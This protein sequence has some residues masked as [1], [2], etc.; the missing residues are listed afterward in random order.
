MILRK[1]FSQLIAFCLAA[2]ASMPSGTGVTGFSN[3]ISDDLAQ[4]LGKSP[5]SARIW[6]SSSDLPLAGRVGIQ[7]DSAEGIVYFGQPTTGYTRT[8]PNSLSVGVPFLDL[9]AGLLVPDNKS[10][11]QFRKYNDSLMVSFIDYKISGY[12][13]A[14][15][16][17]SAQVL[18]EDSKTSKDHPSL[19]PFRVNWRLTKDVVQPAFSTQANIKFF[20][21][22][23]EMPGVPYEWL[24]GA[25]LQGQD[26]YF[27][28]D[29]R[30]PSDS[31]SEFSSF[32]RPLTVTNTEGTPSYWRFDLGDGVGGCDATSPTRGCG[33]G[34]QASWI[35]DLEM[36]PLWGEFSS[37]ELT[38]RAVGNSI[39]KW[40]VWF[41]EEG[42]AHSD[43]FLTTE[44]SPTN[45]VGFKTDRILA[46]QF[47]SNAKSVFR[48]DSMANVSVDRFKVMAGYVLTGGH[49][50][51]SQVILRRDQPP[52]LRF[53]GIA[54][55]TV[56]PGQGALTVR[57]L[58][59]TQANPTV[60]LLK[61]ANV[62]RSGTADAAGVISW[63]DIPSGDYTV[64]VAKERFSYQPDVIAWNATS[65]VSQILVQQYEN[66]PAF[67]PNPPTP[68]S[69]DEGQEVVIQLKNLASDPRGA[70]YSLSWSVVSVSGDPIP[71]KLD[72]VLKTLRLGLVNGDV[73]GSMTLQL[74]ATSSGGATTTAPL[75]V[76][77]RPVN[78]APRILATDWSVAAGA[79]LTV[80]L[81][82]T[83]LGKP[84]WVED[85]DDGFLNLIWSAKLASGA[86]EGAV[87]TVVDRKLNFQA[88]AGFSGVVVI[89]LGVKD[90]IGA[91]TVKQIPIKVV[92]P[93]VEIYGLKTEQTSTGDLKASFF[94]RYSLEPV[95]L[96]NSTVKLLNPSSGTWGAAPARLVVL[97][98]PGFRD[99]RWMDGQ[100]EVLIDRSAQWTAD[101]V[102]LPLSQVLQNG[103]SLSGKLPLS[104]DGKTLEKDLSYLGLDLSGPV[105]L[106]SASSSGN[107]PLIHAEWKWLEPGTPKFLRLSLVKGTDR[108]ER[109]VSIPS[110]A[111]SVDVPWVDPSWTYDGAIPSTLPYLRDGQDYLVELIGED[112]LGNQG[113]GSTIVGVPSSKY[114]LRITTL[115]LEEVPP[116]T[117][118][119]CIEGKS[120]WKGCTYYNSYGGDQFTTGRILEVPRD[121][122]SI[123]LEDSRYQ[124]EIVD[125]MPGSKKLG[126]VIFEHSPNYP[127][128][129][130]DRDTAPDMKIYLHRRNFLS[131][132][133]V[134]VEQEIGTGDFVFKFE[135]NRF[136]GGIIDTVLLGLTEIV[137]GVKRDVEIHLPVTEYN[138]STPLEADSWTVRRTLEQIRAQGGVGLFSG[139]KNRAVRYIGAAARFRSFGNQQRTIPVRDSVVFQA[140][141]LAR[142]WNVLDPDGPASTDDSR[143]VITSGGAAE[144][145]IDLPATHGS[146]GTLKLCLQNDNGTE[147]CNDSLVVPKAERLGFRPTVAGAFPVTGYRNFLEASDQSGIHV[148]AGQAAAASQWNVFAKASGEYEAWIH[149]STNATF[150]DFAVST[151]S[152]KTWVEN[153]LYTESWNQVG[154]I[155]L[156]QGWNSLA[157]RALQGASIQGVLLQTNDSPSPKKVKLAD[158]PFSDAA[159]PAQVTADLE[160]DQIYKSVLKVRDA[161][162][163][164][165]EKESIFPV[166]PD[167]LFGDVTLEQEQATGDLLLRAGQT[168]FIP[169]PGGF[170]VRLAPGTPAIVPDLDSAD[171]LTIRIPRSRIP[172]EF[173]GAAGLS[174]SGPLDSIRILTTKPVTYHWT[175]RS[176]WH[177]GILGSWS[178]KTNSHSETRS[179]ADSTRLSWTGFVPWK[180]A[181]D[182]RALPKPVL[183]VDYAGLDSIRLKVTG[184]DDS[185]GQSRQTMSGKLKVEWTPGSHCASSTAVEIPF[186]QIFEASATGSVLF[187]PRLSSAS[188]S[189]VGG[190]ADTAPAVP[191]LRHQWL[192]NVEGGG[193]F[194]M[195]VLPTPLA[196]EKRPWISFTIRNPSQTPSTTKLWTVPG[197]YVGDSRQNFEF[198]LVPVGTTDPSTP[199]WHQ[200]SGYS[201][202]WHRQNDELVM[203]SGDQELQIRMIDP[204]VTFQALGLRSSALTTDPTEVVSTLPF[205]GTAGMN[206]VF[207][208]APSLASGTLHGFR[209]SAVDRV[210]NVSTDSVTIST[211]AATAKLPTVGIAMSPWNGSG[212]ITGDVASATFVPDGRFVLPAD[213]QIKAWLRHRN[214]TTGALTT[215]STE[216]TVVHGTDGSWTASL[217]GLTARGQT[218]QDFE[219]GERTVLVAWVQSASGRGNRSAIDF[220]VLSETRPGIVAG[221]FLDG[222]ANTGLSFEVKEAWQ[223][224]GSSTYYADLELS[225]FKV[226]EDDTAVNHLILRGAKVAFVQEGTAKRLTNVVGGR[227][228][229]THCK[230]SGTGESLCHDVAR[231]PWTLGRWGGFLEVESVKPELQGT[232]GW[233][234]AVARAELV[235]D[236]AR[237]SR[238]SDPFQLADAGIVGSDDPAFLGKVNFSKDRFWF[239]NVVAANQAEEAFGIEACRTVIGRT[240][241]GLEI[242][243]MGCK[244]EVGPFLTFPLNIQTDGPWS[245]VG[246][247]FDSLTDPYKLTWT[248]GTG[249]GKKWIAGEPESR[250]TISVPTAA[251]TVEKSSL[252]DVRGASLWGYDIRSYKFGPTGV[253]NLVFDL[254]LPDSKLSP[255]QN[256]VAQRVKSFSGMTIVSDATIMQGAPVL[257]GT[258]TS[259]DPAVLKLGASLRLDDVVSWTYARQDGIGWVL[260]PTA[261]SGKTV[262]LSKQQDEGWKYTKIGGVDQPDDR[263]KFP[264]TTL[265]IG[266]G[267]YVS[268]SSSSQDVVISTGGATVSAKLSVDPNDDELRISVASPSVV[269]SKFFT[270]KGSMTF[271]SEVVTDPEL[272]LDPEFG[273]ADIEGTGSLGTST[274]AATKEVWIGGLPVVNAIPSG[275]YQILANRGRMFVRLFKPQMVLHDLI[276]STLSSAPSAEVQTAVFTTDRMPVAVGAELDVPSTWKEWQIPGSIGSVQLDKMYLEA[277]S[278][279]DATSKT[280]TPGLRLQ[281]PTVVKLGGLFEKMGLDGYRLPLKSV[282]MGLKAKTGGL[283]TS[284]MSLDAL[285]WDLEFETAPI[286]FALDLELTRDRLN[287]LF[288]GTYDKAKDKTPVLVKLSTQGWPIYAKYQ[289]NALEM[290]LKNWEVELTDS[291]PLSAMRNTS[292]HL[293]ELTVQTGP[294]D[295]VKTFKASGTKEFPDDLAITSDVI[296]KGFKDPVTQAVRAV[297]VKLGNDEGDAKKPYF[298]LTADSIKIGDKT[299]NL[300]CGGTSSVVKLS[301]SGDFMGEVCVEI[302][303]SL[304]I[305]PFKASKPD[306]WATGTP[307]PTPEDPKARKKI[308]LKLTVKDGEFGIT[309]QNARLR[310]IPMK[311]VFDNGVD[312]DLTATVLVKDGSLRLREA[313]AIIKLGPETE[314]GWKKA[315]G[316]FSV[317]VP[318]LRFYYNT[319]ASERTKNS[320][321]EGKIAF[322]LDPEVGMKVGKCAGGGTGLVQFDA[323]IEAMTSVSLKWDFE[324]TDFACEVAGLDL[325][326]QKLKIGT[327]ADELTVAAHVIQVSVKSDAAKYLGKGQDAK[328]ENQVA[329]VQSTN[330][331]V[332]PHSGKGFRIVNLMYDGSRQKP[333]TIDSLKPI[334]FGDLDN[335]A[336]EIPGIGVTVVSRLDVMPLFDDD[337]GVAL[338]N[339]RLALPSSMGGDTLNTNFSVLFN[340][341]SPYVHVRGKMNELPLRIKG[342][343]L[344]PDVGLDDAEMVIKFNKRLNGDEGWSFEGKAALNMQGG[345]GKLDAELA[346]ETP[347]DCKVGVCKAVVSVR[348][349]DGAR[350]PLGTTGLYIAGLK[351]AFYDG[352]YSPP[353]AQKCTGQPMD[354]GM[355]VELAVFLEAEK[356]S[357]LN[358][359]TG[360]WVQLNRINFGVYGEF[361]MMDGVADADACAAVFAGGKQFHGQVHV[362]LHALLSARGS[363]VIDIWSDNRGKSMAAEATA[364]VGLGRGAIIRSRW[365]KFPRTTTWFG[366]FVTRF[367]RFDNGSNGFTSGVRAMGKTW[368]VGFVDGGFRLG[369]V[370]QYKLAKPT[371]S[372]LFLAGSEYR[373]MPLGLV[374][375]GGEVI[376]INVG[377]AEG[378]DWRGAQIQLVEANTKAGALGGAAKIS[379][380]NVTPISGMEN[381]LVA[382]REDSANIHS[383]TWINANRTLRTLVAIPKSAGTAPTGEVREDGDANVASKV[384]DLQVLMG[385]IDPTVALTATKC[386]D[387]TS[388][389]CINGSVVD[390]RKDPA[391]V[392]R[393]Y[394]SDELALL[395][396]EETDRSEKTVLWQ[397]H[398][399]KFW[400]IPTWDTTGGVGARD[401]AIPLDIPSN[402]LTNLSSCMTPLAV[403]QRGVSL[404]D[405]RWKPGR[406]KTGRYRL[407]AGVEGV[408]LLPTL[409]A[410]GLPDSFLLDQTRRILSK[411]G[412][413]DPFA[414]AVTYPD[415]VA[416][417]TALAV[418]G[419]A[420]DSTQS[421]TSNQRRTLFARWTPQGHPDVVGHMIRWTDAKNAQHLFH[422]GADGQW[423]INVPKS[424]GYKATGNWTPEDLKGGILGDMP[425]YDWMFQVPTKLEVAPALFQRVPG[426]DSFYWAPRWDLAATWLAPTSNP[427][428]VLGNAVGGTDNLLGAPAVTSQTVHLNESKTDTLRIPVTVFNATP[429][430]NLASLYG[431]LDMELLSSTG[432]PLTPS[433]RKAA[434]AFSVDVEAW[435]LAGGTLKIPYA[436]S[437]VA[438]ARVCQPRLVS[439]EETLVL[440]TSVCKQNDTLKPATALGDYQ[441]RLRLWSE[442]RLESGKETTVMF[443]VKVV[444]PEAHIDRVGPDYLLGER[445]QKIRLEASKLWVDASGR[446]PVVAIKDGLGNWV[447]FVPNGT[448]SRGTELQLVPD[449][450]GRVD[451]NLVIQLG[452][453]YSVPN[454]N[455]FLT[456]HVFHRDAQGFTWGTDQALTYVPEPS[457]IACKASQIDDIVT[458]NQIA[459][460]FVGFYP[461]TVRLSDTVTALFSEIHNPDYVNFQVQ[462]KRGTDSVMVPVLQYDAGRVRFLLPKTLGGKDLAA[463][464]RVTLTLNI[465]DNSAGTNCQ[466]KHWTQTLTTEKPLT[467]ANIPRQLKAS[468][469]PGDILVSHP[470][471]LADERIEWVRGTPP[472]GAAWSWIQGNPTNADI[473]QTDWLNVRIRRPEAGVVWQDRWL[474]VTPPREISLGTQ[475]RT[476]RRRDTLAVGTPIGWALSPI[477]TQGHNGTSLPLMQCRWNDGTW[478]AC[479]DANLSVNLVQQGALEVR[480]GWKLFTPTGDT[481]IWEPAQSWQ[482]AARSATLDGVQRVSLRLDGVRLAHLI[483][484]QVTNAVVR[485]RRTGAEL[486]RWDATPPVVRDAEGK[487]LAQQVEV[488]DPTNKRYEAWVEVPQLIPHRSLN[489]ELWLGDKTSTKVPESLVGAHGSSSSAGVVGSAVAGAGAAA[490]VAVGGSTAQGWSSSLW[491]RW[492]PDADEILWSSP[493]LKWGTRRDGRLWL[494]YRGDSVTTAPGALDGQDPILVGATWESP[495]GRLN[496]WLNGQKVAAKMIAAKDERRVEPANVVVGGR[497]AVDELRWNAPRQDDWKLRWESERPGSAL[498]DA[499][500]LSPTLAP[501]VLE[502]KGAVG[503]TLALV[504]GAPVWADREAKISAVPAAW[505]GA[506]WMPGLA[507]RVQDAGSS[508]AWIRSERFA[509]VCAVG[510][511]AWQPMAGWTR[512]ASNL[513]TTLGDRSVWCHPMPSDQ[514]G[515]PAAKSAQ[516]PSNTSL[517]WFL[518]PDQAPTASTPVQAGQVLDGWSLPDPLPGSLKGAGIPKV[519]QGP[520]GFPVQQRTAGG[521]FVLIPPA[522]YVP[523]NGTIVDTVWVRD[524]QGKPVP[525]LVVWLDSDPGLD[526][527]TVLIAPPRAVV[528]RETSP[529]LVIHTQGDSIVLPCGDKPR[530]NLPMP[531]VG[532]RSS[533]ERVFS[534]NYRRPAELW[535]ALGPNA[536]TAALEG[537]ES[538]G[539]VVLDGK[540]W[541]QWTR[542]VEPGRFTWDATLVFPGESCANFLLSAIERWR[543]LPDWKLASMRSSAVG[544]NAVMQGG[545][546]QIRNLEIEHAAALSLRS[547]QYSMK[548]LSAT[549][550]GRDLV[551]AVLGL[552]TP[553]VEPRLD[554][555]TGASEYVEVAGQFALHDLRADLLNADSVQVDLRSLRASGKVRLS[556]TQHGRA[557]FTGGI[558]A[559]LFRDRNGDLRYTE[560]IDDP[561]GMEQVGAIASGET[562]QVEFVLDQAARRYPE[563]VYVAWID[564]AAI[565]PERS[566]GDHIAVAGNPCREAKAMRWLDATAGATRVDGTPVALAHLR[567]TDHD[568]RIRSLDS[569]DQVWYAQ[570]KVCRSLGS[571]ESSWCVAAA[572][573][574][575]LADLAIRDL[576]GDGLPEI[577]AGDVALRQ[578]G[579]TLWDFQ[580]LVGDVLTDLDAD[581]RTDTVHGTQDCRWA[582]SGSAGEVLWS[583]GSNCSKPGRY[584]KISEL[585]AHPDQC[586]DVSVSGV[587]IQSG[588]TKLRVANAGTVTLPTG[589]S[590]A[591][592]NA[593]GSVERGITATSNVLLP[594][595]FEDLELAA[596]V[597][598]DDRVQ[599]KPGTLRALGIWE[600]DATNNTRT[601]P[602][603]VQP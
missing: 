29:G 119:I 561:I 177:G 324:M 220:A 432:Q 14:N 87:V 603:E 229:A 23:V 63:T 67:S 499:W 569:L 368:G 528:P 136:L 57:I 133:G 253:T 203:Q 389:V 250:G 162:G 206:E 215:D 322:A 105:A 9:G 227:L 500:V 52:A 484:G 110:G 173:T 149:W 201:P 107:W 126:A 123:K 101:R 224:S 452:K 381:P 255:A 8:T 337:P 218:L 566:V 113:G 117:G 237:P 320:N 22:K 102:T 96:Q 214:G 231:M 535:L 475:Q 160:P 396:A 398:N 240:T 426:T 434:P 28:R 166:Q 323:P 503:D 299:Y 4:P 350:Y 293:E 599:I 294:G 357:V 21:G 313:S 79:L 64:D 158:L 458:N 354:K 364:D 1:I 16:R 455:N 40:K 42:S 572:G 98:A 361:V 39:D 330:P 492:N 495:S 447:G 297:S 525:L 178:C 78:D 172:T 32:P 395:P 392:K 348:L 385:L 174:K 507:F 232:T 502:S 347:G 570:G 7:V 34:V 264:F 536:R 390:F 505:T 375:Q 573:A 598:P 405:C 601:V 261:A 130:E 340:G 338:D 273:L 592:T 191:R 399:L 445:T 511:L 18:F 93:L 104:A 235:D 94:S 221:P 562:R 527:T 242:N 192:D 246:A 515:L 233:K 58:A 534:V 147:T 200:G 283:G 373:L 327:H 326:V 548:L 223:K 546:H 494:G 115:N 184:L 210:G 485:I 114:Q 387:D 73:S 325:L 532:P 140:P 248:P 510:D 433:A 260:T 339:V 33:F 153:S 393:S 369:N 171:H 13:S 197:E 486:S 164:I 38:Y 77:V 12:G 269:L 593:S 95:G 300:A 487:L 518:L 587:Q 454:Q 360:V 460:D 489:L 519:Q 597:A 351:G 516:I 584:A 296:L 556:V 409:T 217:S 2:S 41:F 27:M 550:T 43:S 195:M 420:L 185:S 108:H 483:S 415:P 278:D 55:A 374:L 437:A 497:Y 383:L 477:A 165:T 244:P 170:Q 285:D 359:T 559:V 345:L 243:T 558:Y 202:G 138:E 565:S 80:K 208:S 303:D 307:A 280:W 521:V 408:D 596:P 82:S 388:V 180:S 257:K 17:I 89:E 571:A 146:R 132:H 472:N 436:L 355:K 328:T 44:L 332:K 196:P 295:F 428:A 236:A 25:A 71:Y 151:D 427:E 591:L 252:R 155:Q 520:D 414:I 131:E 59:T 319:P 474:V 263:L 266:P 99:G 56:P 504:A 459:M 277:T 478:E 148:P 70:G 552:G 316:P 289:Q 366:P 157:I 583:R 406:W 493:E 443:P 187:R 533:L 120:G 529:S 544:G 141:L 247:A 194:P 444:P 349:K 439:K 254:V 589:I 469:L 336:L 284:N 190:W 24:L 116:P 488:W 301:L 291:F 514:S 545:L 50:D 100:Y 417:P 305:Y 181:H 537:W 538:A 69:M 462:V 286:G 440:D 353:C 482:V 75:S 567:D 397:R 122:Y 318:N 49:I 421:R 287:H 358:G 442:A 418:Y 26:L 152:G 317:M 61:D 470:G 262:F 308:Q 145:A 230:L 124:A 372:G 81:D 37:V 103:S 109:I 226:Q 84:V 121:V 582:V 453:E 249:S 310:S 31:I 207:V 91:E 46:S 176:C 272:R 585:P 275:R 423:N 111:N 551:S 281:T 419:S 367:G 407:M 331:A 83:K 66:K 471:Q 580:S 127:V 422:A 19:V 182:L 85:P 125:V 245:V 154:K 542:R 213:A 402:E 526:S 410:G 600:F 309:L 557:K 292:F 553:R 312:A 36:A 334:G 448:S 466:D 506:T 74:S 416:A 315:Y 577:V 491:V 523:G 45:P 212:W 135:K 594:G 259:T 20:D 199:L 60:R 376:S 179:E 547:Q 464:E 579:T 513:G 241:A 451:T 480:L 560:G 461:K 302:A 335:M 363:F 413:S 51:I 72:P 112:R 137:N 290:S 578:D 321:F 311:P 267:T 186:G 394:Q 586:A 425:S 167:G 204:G 329:P 352:Y 106:V 144:W 446:K 481:T 344:T 343:Q 346:V 438:N 531:V 555:E 362:Q 47:L 498:W 234:L 512:Q 588:K 380:D 401:S 539:E 142:D 239:R 333:L 216:V 251:V 412:E 563:E 76:T 314:P 463:N 183:S 150:G 6:K 288:S 118:Q 590:V 522:K 435:K 377:A 564:L 378:V 306:V 496:L 467:G 222:P 554:P 540:I 365:F 188:K 169:T 274:E 391:L 92:P 549:A 265:E 90:A 159:I 574:G 456:L 404:S 128:Y 205:T 517:S 424:D 54:S 379:T 429:G 228:A 15:L 468:R 256:G 386:T 400:A 304:A 449:S 62:V 161:F 543:N 129:E 225:S 88:P 473:P 356:P 189:V 209:V 97:Q 524:A 258:G 163:Q 411:P 175:T 382:L 441:V 48:V 219:N 143:R 279:Y 168:R 568:G 271:S 541:T 465:P 276:T 476:L 431:H 282:T 479:S 139:S 10:K 193:F 457:K 156:K 86:P 490:T 501:R 342:I 198:R 371:T 509:K 581:G 268:A 65:G 30:I 508:A 298:Q 35:S 403:G 575:S 602:A 370:G 450:L 341:V 134:S 11:L 5:V 270:K 530:W 430:T 576:D 211:I 384:D 68:I 3:W 53:F 595:D 238:N